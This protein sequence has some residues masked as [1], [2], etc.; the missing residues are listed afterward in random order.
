MTLGGSPQAAMRTR[1]NVG[2]GVQRNVSKPPSRLRSEG[3][4]N[5]DIVVADK[6]KLS[7]LLGIGGGGGGGAGE[8]LMAGARPVG[9]REGLTQQQQQWEGQDRWAGPSQQQWGEPSQQS[10]SSA[11]MRPIPVKPP[12]EAMQYVNP[13]KKAQN[14][15]ILKRMQQAGGG[16]GEGK[17]VN[18]SPT[19]L[20][21]VPGSPHGSLVGGWQGR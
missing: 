2:G 12:H 9:S 10:L 11:P 5:G 13:L 3:P 15:T 8:G 7:M 18:G 6:S 4:E 20:A 14:Q 16:G 17:S 21:A 1:N 19:G